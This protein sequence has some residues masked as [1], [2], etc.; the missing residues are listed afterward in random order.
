M[1]VV[2]VTVWNEHVSERREAAAAQVYPRGLHTAVAEGIHEVLGDAVEVRTATLDESDDGLPEAVLATTDVLVWWGHVAHEQ[3]AD[4][5][6]ARVRA[7]VLAGMGL[8]VLHSG[9]LSKVFTS[10]MGT[11]CHLRWRESDD[12]ELIWTVHPSHPIA[13]GVPHPLEIEQHEMYGEFF[14]IPPP[15]ELVFVS[16]FSGGEV[17]RSGCCFSRGSGRIFYFSPGHETN[18]VYHLPGVR[19]VLA[20]AVGWAHNPTPLP[21]V[22]TDSQES[23]LGWFRGQREPHTEG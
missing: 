9:H 17:F 3:V 16:S 19:R 22:L 11:S 13:Q 21:I 2:R 1:A 8:V 7:H 23:R 4:A 20:N 5:T 6:V 18:P 10:L 15:D 14:D 12:R